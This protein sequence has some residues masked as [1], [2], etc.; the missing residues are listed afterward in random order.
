MAGQEIFLFESRN[1]TEFKGLNDCHIGYNTCSH[2]Q[3][4][5]NQP[6]KAG[7]WVVSLQ[8]ERSRIRTG[9]KSRNFRKQK[10]PGGES[11]REEVWSGS[12]P[13]TRT[14]PV[15]SVDTFLRK[16]GRR[17]KRSSVWPVTM[18]RTPQGIVS[19]LGKTA[20]PVRKRKPPALSTFAVREASG[21]GRFKNHSDLREAGDEKKSAPES[22]SYGARKIVVCTAIIS[23]SDPEECFPR[24]TQKNRTDFSI[25]QNRI[26]ILDQIQKPQLSKG[27]RLLHPH[28][29]DRF[30]DHFYT[31]L[32]QKT[33]GQG[34][35]F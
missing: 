4:N 8:I 19:G 14:G 12:I 10:L 24:P 23:F 5:Q 27:L 20:A 26:S 22:L 25:R 9:S 11:A 15:L 3:V 18:M 6:R 29:H 34:P 33:F 16:V 2:G 30:V 31:L 7:R 28:N 1:E 32:P 21:R 35:F 17:R 13:E